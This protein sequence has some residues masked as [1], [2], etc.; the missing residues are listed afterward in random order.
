MDERQERGSVGTKAGFDEWAIM[1]T[2]TH[3]VAIEN[4]GAQAITG[5][6]VY[7]FNGASTRNPTTITGL[8]G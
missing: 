1:D 5:L 6:W 2:R 8:P 3:R 7:G 4:R